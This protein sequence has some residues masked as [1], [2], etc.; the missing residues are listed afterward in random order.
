M[1]LETRNFGDIE[2]LEED[3]IDFREGL[4]GFPK[5]RR[6]VL[7]SEADSPVSFLQSVDGGDVSFVVVDMLAFMPDYNP[8]VDVNFIGDL[9]AYVP[10]NFLIFNIATIF[11]NLKDSTVNLKA[12]IIINAVDKK[13]KQV[14]CE[15][16][17]YSVKA[18]LFAASGPQ[19][20]EGEIC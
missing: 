13:G 4:P 8:H 11:D 16:E 15:N 5:D 1:K 7:L 6:F 12:P 10:E 19:D 17:E 9:G 18:P 3:I 20:E 14:V 2:I